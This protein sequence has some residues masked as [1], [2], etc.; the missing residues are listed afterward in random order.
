[1]AHY[2]FGYL[3][4]PTRVKP[5]GDNLYP[6]FNLDGGSDIVQDVPVSTLPTGHNLAFNTVNPCDALYTTPDNIEYFYLFNTAEAPVRLVLQQTI[7]YGIFEVGKK[8]RYQARV[9]TVTSV[10]T[11]EEV[12]AIHIATTTD[13]NI[14]D[15]D[16]AMIGENQDYKLRWIDFE[17][18]DTALGRAN[19]RHGVGLWEIVTTAQDTRDIAIYEL[20]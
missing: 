13:L 16:N 14:L 11:G 4:N 5:I 7:G 3:F 1:M 20:G 6:N 19:F 9:R 10:P 15:G 17:V 2:H 18:T 12:R 8:Y